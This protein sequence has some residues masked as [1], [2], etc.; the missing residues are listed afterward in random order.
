MAGKFCQGILAESALWIGPLVSQSLPVFIGPGA[1]I[2]SNVAEVG[3]QKDDCT[4][5]ICKNNRIA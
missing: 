2:E 5:F 1:G 3:E 4:E